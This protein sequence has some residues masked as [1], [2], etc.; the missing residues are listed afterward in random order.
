MVARALAWSWAAAD[1]A[2]GA[3]G[4]GVGDDGGGVASEEG[5]FGGEGDAHVGHEAGDDEVGVACGVDEFGEVGV[6]EGV[7]GDLT[8]MGSSGVGDSWGWIRPMSA[9]MS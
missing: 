2:Q 8:T 7:G 4:A 5:S 3:G 1:V 6:H 9:V